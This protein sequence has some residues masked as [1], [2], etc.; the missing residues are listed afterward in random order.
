MTDCCFRVLPTE[1]RQAARDRAE[2]DDDWSQNP[3]LNSEDDPNEVV[4]LFSP[5]SRLILMASK[6]V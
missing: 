1:Q 6:K 5:V 4:S 2:R 3:D